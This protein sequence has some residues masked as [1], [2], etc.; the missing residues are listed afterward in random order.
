MHLTATVNNNG[1]YWKY[2]EFKNIKSTYVINENTAPPFCYVS[3]S[4][5]FIDSRRTCAINLYGYTVGNYG[6]I[7]DSNAHRYVEFWA[8]S[9]M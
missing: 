2:S 6:A 7:L 1:G 4:K 5:Q 9:G 8:G 3:Y